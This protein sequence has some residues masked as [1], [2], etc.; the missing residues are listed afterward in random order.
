MSPIIRRCALLSVIGFITQ[1]PPD[2]S[3]APVRFECG[4]TISNGEVA[5]HIVGNCY[6][7]LGCY[8]CNSALELAASDDAAATTTMQEGCNLGSWHFRCDGAGICEG[9]GHSC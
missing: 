7:N 5:C 8:C 4:G 3:A 1:M 2:V 9:D 6:G